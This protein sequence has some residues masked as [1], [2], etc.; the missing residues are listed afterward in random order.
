GAQTDSSE[1]QKD[2]ITCLMDYGMV[3][4]L[5]GRIN[6]AIPIKALTFD[7]MYEILIGVANSPLVDI[8]VLFDGVYGITLKFEEDALRE[9]CDYSI[10][11]QL[12]ARSLHSILDGAAH[13]AAGNFDSQ[14]VSVTKEHVLEYI[15]N[16]ASKEEYSRTV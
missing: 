7:D 6:S 12:G 10:K 4:E 11:L 14:N 5:A 1:P 13:I 2:V 8:Q 15:N 9:V 16:S 3:P